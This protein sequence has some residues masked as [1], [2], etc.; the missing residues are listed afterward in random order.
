MV[1]VMNG[2]VGWFPDPDG[3]NGLRYF[4]GQQWTQIAPSPPTPTPSPTP[5]PVSVV[6]NNTVTATSPEVSRAGAWMFLAICLFNPWMWILV[7]FL[8]FTFKWLLIGAAVLW[9]ALAYGKYHAKQQST[10]QREKDKLAARAEVQD[11]LYLQGDPRGTHG[12]YPPPPEEDL[13]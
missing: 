10:E 4:D 13:R 6:V 8:W 7:L 9:I 2:P 1:A 11:E 5:P 3:G 12:R